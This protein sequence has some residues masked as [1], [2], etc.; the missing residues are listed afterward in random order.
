MKRAVFVTLAGLALAACG[1]VASAGTP[2]LHPSKAPAVIKVGSTP[3]LGSFLTDASGHTLY[4]F[5]PEHD[6]HITCT[7]QCASVWP[8]LLDP[9]GLL[10]TDAT[11]PGTLTTIPRDNTRQVTYSDWPLYTYSGDTAPGDTNGQGMFG[12]W[13]VAST[14]LME[15][16]PTPTPAPTVAPTQAPVAPPATV[17]PTV[18][19]TVRATPIPTMH[20]TPAPTSCIPGSNGGDHDGDNNGGPSDGDGCQ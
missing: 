8:P 17:R 1:Q 14:S 4:Y 7:G 18:R 3:A 6:S 12:K 20:A 13:F 15:D 2:S 11:L 9:S 5:T 10:T 16:L 19:A